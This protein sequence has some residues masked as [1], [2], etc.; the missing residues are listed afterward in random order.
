MSETEARFLDP[1][2]VII[3]ASPQHPIKARRI[4]YFEDPK[5]SAMMDAQEGMQLPYP[6][7][8]RVEAVAGP[9]AQVEKGN[10]GESSDGGQNLVATEL[11][12][13]KQSRS[14]K[15]RLAKPTG[16]VGGSLYPAD[17]ERHADIPE[18]WN[19]LIAE[20]EA[21]EMS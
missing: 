17:L 7:Q 10:V 12:K 4:K 2:D 18:T 20:G 3:L 9:V 8:Q 15:L 11:S 19:A 6:P 16:G 21:F 13:P 5:F 1:D 14:R